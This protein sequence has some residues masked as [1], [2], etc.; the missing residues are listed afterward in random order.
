MRKRI[1]SVISVIIWIVVCIP[2]ARA[3]DLDTLKG[4]WSAK[5]TSDEGQ[6]YILEVEINKKKF[7]FRIVDSDKHLRLYAEGDVK[8]EK[9]GPFKAITFFNIKAGESE[10][11]LEEVS[12]ERTS[13]YT[14]GENNW[15]IAS[16]FDKERDQKPSVE[17]YQ[18]AHVAQK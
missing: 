5:R 14:L 1:T 4:K 15:T 17:V 10:S 9:A 16:N 6:P 18:K 3:D 12:D 11:A 7:T 13:I 2:L 8:L